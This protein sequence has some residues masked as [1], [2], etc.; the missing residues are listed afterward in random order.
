VRI[1]PQNERGG[2][3]VNAQ[4]AL[5]VAAGLV[6]LAFACSTFERWLAGRARH[7]LAWSVSLLLFALASAAMAVG[8][9]GGWYPATFRLFYLFGAILNV[10]FLALGTVYLLGGRRAGDPAA[11]GICLFSAF[12]AGVLAV[13]PL[14]A[15][16]PVG[17]LPRG[18]EVFGVL[19]RVLAAVASSGGALVVVG[20]AVWSAVRDRRGRA[21]WAN[22][23]I[24]LGTLVLSGGGLLNSVVDEMTGFAITLVA[25]VA[26]IFAGFLV[27]T[28]AAGPGAAPSPSRP[29]AARPRT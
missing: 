3:A 22:V 12:A 15:E 1:H 6:A 19:P 13:A 11:A 5:A 20:G 16:V 27:A 10:P 23:L 18:S 24:A 28:T 25:G 9:G 4:T 17:E 29:E 14:S 21:L 2:D 8:A 7:Q 26:V